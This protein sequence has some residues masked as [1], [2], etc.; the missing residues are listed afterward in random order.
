MPP[1]TGLQ[2]VSARAGGGASD[3]RLHV[4]IIM[5]GNGRWAK[6]RGMPRVLGHRA[7]VNALKRTVEGAQNQ[8]VGVLTVFGFSTEN[9][10]RPA[11]EVSELMG[12][13]KAYVESDL[14]RLARAGVRVRI[15]GR[16][17][18]LTPDLAEVIERAEK[19]TAQNTEFVLQVA[20]NYGGQAD[21]TDAARAFAEKV[22]R[23]EAKAADLTEE[24]FERFLSTASAPPPDLI[25][26]TSGE[27]RISNF[28]LWECAYAELVFQ[29]VLWPD[30]GPEPLAAAIA[31][32]RRRDRRY[33]G[34]AADD[35]A[36]AG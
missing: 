24:T 35:V 27:R 26:R 11:Q 19:R 13:L 6:Q 1:T 33:G 29:D 5:D 28:L 30:Y 14:E 25:V 31:E 3:Q 4:A 7:G 10:R 2:N 22:E 16:R 9:W 15:I 34:I 8:N 12:L 23:G 20:F 17:T 21:I 32:Y 36:V 18:G